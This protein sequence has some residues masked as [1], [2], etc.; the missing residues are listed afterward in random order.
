[1]SELPFGYRQKDFGYV[2]LGVTH[3]CSLA[4][5]DHRLWMI[6]MGRPYFSGFALGELP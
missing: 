3:G 4:V 6:T 2:V 1:M 5:L